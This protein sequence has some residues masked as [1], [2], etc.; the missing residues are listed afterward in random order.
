MENK[1]TCPNCK[2]T[3]S[4]DPIIEDAAINAGS[5]ARIV[6]CEC[7][8]DINYWAIRSQLKEQKKLVWKIRAMFQSFSKS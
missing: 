4:N 2:T 5:G 8:E 3:I 1:I 6:T 7:G